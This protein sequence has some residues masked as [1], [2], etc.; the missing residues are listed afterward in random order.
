MVRIDIIAGLKNAVERGYSLQQAKQTLLNSGYSQNDID[1][2]TNYLL[3][4]PNI[5]QNI[6]NYLQVNPQQQN[7]QNIRTPAQNQ[8]HK[9]NKEK[10]FPFLLVFLIFILLVLVGFLIISILFKEQLVDFFKNIIG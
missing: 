10:K 3:G 7:L 9:I 1:E 5:R 6:Q 4:T 2:A 8:S